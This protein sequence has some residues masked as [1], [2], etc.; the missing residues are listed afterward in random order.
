MTNKQKIAIVPGSFDPITNGHISIVKRAAMEY[1]IVYLAVMINP[2]KKYMF[3]LE[4]RK[5]IADLALK[6]IDNVK[7]ISSEGMLWELALSL[8]ACAI[9]KGYR[10]EA[11]LK[12][13]KEMA[14]FN[15][16]H[17][18][19]AKTVLLKADEDLCDVSSTKIREL[20]ISDKSAEQYVPTEALNEIKNI[21]KNK[22]II[23]H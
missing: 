4:E 15:Y 3:E 9:V 2:N 5:R 17:N 14:E 21:L 12:Y 8:N 18:P 6:N 19:N 7:V 11:D 10:N 16:A 13:E 1:D 23:S 22:N 20:L